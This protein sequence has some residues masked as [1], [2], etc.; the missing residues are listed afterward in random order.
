M[1]VVV[2]VNGE[3]IIGVSVVEKGII[4]GIVIDMDGKFLLNV[5]VGIIL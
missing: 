4:N 1:G 2:D 3:L 5:K